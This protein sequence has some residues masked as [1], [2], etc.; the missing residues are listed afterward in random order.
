MVLLSLVVSLLLAADRPER[1]ALIVQAPDSP[2]RLAHATI[3]S[4][5]N[6][7]PVLLYEATDVTD[8]PID[9]FTVMAFVFSSEGALKARQVAPGR[10]SLDARGSKYSTLVLDGSPIDPTD[11]IVIGVNQAQRVNSEVWWRA[12]L[13]PAAEAAVPLKKR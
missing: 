13:Q 11:A 9:Q 1:P 8:D 12:D 3:L 5:S 6:G 7:P 10:R 2:V 4:P